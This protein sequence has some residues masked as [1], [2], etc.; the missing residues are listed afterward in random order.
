MLC[1]GC[2]Q[3][4]L[5][6]DELYCGHCRKMFMELDALPPSIE[7]VSGIALSRQCVLKNV[8]SHDITVSVDAGESAPYLS[9]DSA[10]TINLPANESK[11]VH[12]VLNDSLFPESVSRREFTYFF[13]V[14]NNPKKTRAVKVVVQKG[15]RPEL[16]PAF[17]DFGRMAANEGET[18]RKVAVKNAGNAPLV[19]R[20]VE[21]SER[22]AL[23]VK[24]NLAPPVS[25]APGK[26]LS[27]ALAWDSGLV[28]GEAEG[29]ET[30]FF[31]YFEGFDKPVFLPAKGG[32]VNL[33]LEAE[34]AAVVIPEAF[35]RRSFPAKVA[36]TNTGNADV[37]IHSLET[38]QPWL[39]VARQ[40]RTVTLLCRETLEAG[41]RPDYRSFFDKY[42]FTVMVKPEGL[43][44]GPARGRVTA[45]A[46]H[47]S[48]S[49]EIPVDINVVTPL[50]CPHF[51]GI[52][53]G[54]TNSVVAVYDPDRGE[55]VCIA[56]DEG[57]GPSDA[58]IP[59]VLVFRGSPDNYIIGRQA[60][61]EAV[62]HPESS[63]HSIKR[64]MGA[65]TE[66]PFFGRNFKPEE[67]ASRI[68]R[69]L[70]DYAEDAHIKM[71]GAYYDMQKAIVTVP[72]KFEHREIQ[73]ILNACDGC[74][75]ETRQDVA[76]RLD[77]L[78]KDKLGIE[79]RTGIIL[80]EPSAAAFYYVPK[81]AR[82]GGDLAERLKRGERVN[83]V[84]VDY[85]GGTLDVVVICAS[86]LQKGGWFIE[87]LG[88]DG[89]NDIGGDAID[90]RIFKRVLPEC[91][92]EFPD[93]DPTLISDRYEDILKRKERGNWDETGS[94][95]RV[96]AAR[97][98]WK[99]A[100]ESAKIA[101]SNSGEAQFNIDGG[102]ILRMNG[103]EAV[104]AAGR[105]FRF[106]IRRTDFEGWI[107]DVLMRMEEVIRSAVHLS[108]LKPQDIHYILHTG[109]S[110]L[111]K[112]ARS[113]V[114]EIFPTIPPGNDILEEHELKFCVAKGAVM[115][116]AQFTGTANV[117]RGVYLSKA[118]G[119]K[120]PHGY[121]VCADDSLFGEVYVP[122]V[123]I[124]SIY[125]NKYQHKF[126]D[127]ILSDTRVI[128]FFR[129]SLPGE[130][131]NDNVLIRG[132]R[133]LKHIATVSI[134]TGHD[135][136]TGDALSVEFDID[137]NKMYTVRVNGSV[138]PL[139]TERFEDVDR[140]IA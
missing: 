94:W 138:I 67:L 12:F 45:L 54:T 48:L 65:K 58:L 34:P 53:F 75:L 98:A 62:V 77:G 125:P 5:K 76:R 71:A 35:A 110:S 88:H 136:E 139:E 1:S 96:L 81:L 82:S 13:R 112:S 49:V 111:M 4:T 119:R 69:R 33:S 103:N 43:P 93:M 68:L 127:M 21:P 116:G 104:A 47:V 124:N 115:Y 50:K 6:A 92:E 117:S 60:V 105:N 26:E 51:I 55:A 97:A 31:F 132:N 59:S 100:A 8:T 3:W 15:P 41:E 66:W 57:G 17:L 102:Y 79:A 95:A 134:P 85:G 46:D 29:G 109:R 80:D 39:T 129:S 74:G 126:E 30:G 107:S 61:Q 90:Y 130:A 64:I 16:V 89:D 114:S 131:E 63:A 52:D 10:S 28:P 83:F 113:R 99:N 118:K 36:I 32:I 120:L 2:S 23:K 84:V 14:N 24:D 37:T 135:P 121:G 128:K 11:T 108:D 133:H 122:I 106:N 70:L 101:L 72:V 78:L 73:A 25:L 87:A 40:S 27:I 7:L 44:E 140:W 123:P 20:G 91:A 86:R 19:L 22:T 42:E 18:V 38:D 137:E 9:F 56:P